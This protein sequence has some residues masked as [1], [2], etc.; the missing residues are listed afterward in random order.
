MVPSI[1]L[2]MDFQHNTL[3]HAAP[4]PS[5]KATGKYREGDANPS[6]GAALMTGLMA[7]PRVMKGSTYAGKAKGAKG[8]NATTAVGMKTAWPGKKSVRGA[9]NESRAATPPPPEGRVSTHLQTDEYI[10]VLYA[11]S[12]EVQASQTY[13]FLDKPTDPLFNPVSPR[14]LSP[15]SSSLLTPDPTPPPPLPFL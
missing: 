3:P 9:W 7:D 5:S 2:T 10:E 8:T 4:L 14:A 6:T 13:A 12:G 1:D 11:H 15:F